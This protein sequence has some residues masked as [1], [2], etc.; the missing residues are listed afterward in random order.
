MFVHAA[1]AVNSNLF[2]GGYTAVYSKHELFGLGIDNDLNSEDISIYPNPAN[3]IVNFN[4][5][6]NVDQVLVTNAI[7]QTVKTFN[8]PDT[9]LE[10]NV[11]TF[12]TG[13]YFVQVK[14]GEAI[15]T[16]KLIVR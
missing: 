16:K 12:K 15:I 14:K 9:N 1:V 11:T 10:L 3:T 6:L 2:N 7:G 13:I 4:L 8:M 5:P